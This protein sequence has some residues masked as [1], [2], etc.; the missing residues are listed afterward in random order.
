VHW[1]SIEN[2]LSHSV[3]AKPGVPL[4]VNRI[5]PEYLERAPSDR[6]TASDFLFRKEPDDEEEEEDGEEDDDENDGLLGVT[7]SR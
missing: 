1:A 7:A 5:A 6:P 3:V 2:R 4:D